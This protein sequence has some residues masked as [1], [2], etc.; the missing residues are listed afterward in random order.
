LLQYLL[1]ASR[2]PLRGPPLYKAEGHKEK[3]GSKKSKKVWSLSLSSLQ[4]VEG[5]AVGKRELD[6]EDVEERTF[7][8]V[9]D[10]KEEEGQDRE[11]EGERLE[12]GCHVDVRAKE[13]VAS[14]VPEDVPFLVTEDS[15]HDYEQGNQPSKEESL[16]SQKD[17]KEEE[18]TYRSRIH[19]QTKF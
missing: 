17:G 13:E 16:L 6:E 12:G 8:P 4:S 9:A 10:Q 11:K 5:E 7:H 15:V 14:H 1:V 18:Q 3:K 2:L 19:F